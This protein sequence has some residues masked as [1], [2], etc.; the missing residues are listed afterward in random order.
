MKLSLVVPCYNEEENVNVF[1]DN[2]KQ[3][4]N[5]DLDYELIFIDDGSKDETLEK[6]KE[7]AKLDKKHVKTISF[8]RN[9]G[10]EAA[11]LAGLKE[12][13]GDYVGIIDADMQQDPK[14]MLEMLDI[15]EK[16][17]YY[18]SVA[19]YQKERKENKV[20]SFFKRNFYEIMNSTSSFEIKQGAS[21]FRL[22]RRAVVDSILLLEEDNRFSKGIFSW[23][24][25][26]T[27]YLPYVPNKREHGSTKFNFV[28]L[29]TYGVGGIVS[30]SIKP[31]KASIIIG[32]IF[33]VLFLISFIAFVITTNVIIG[34]CA[35]ILF[36]ST[37]QLLIMGVICEYLSQ[38]HI[39]SKNRPIY[40]IKETEKD[41]K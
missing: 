12:A 36:I 4:Y 34:L 9:F 10:K 11:I 14:I 41:Q 16:D 35:L 22:F 21:D 31:L 29:L 8:S 28:K 13:K 37:I 3:N 7:L 32:M 38:I 17:N 40:I 30:F 18:D 23:V 33:S 24:G 6:L 25:F 15:L 39:Q 19:A 20:I 27:Y 5:K 1:Y 26:H 2:I